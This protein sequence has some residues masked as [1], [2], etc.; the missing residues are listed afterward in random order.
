MTTH[1]KDSR[2]SRIEATYK[3]KDVE[4]VIDIWYYRPLGYA[5]AVGA[6]RLD[7]SPNTISVVGMLIGM[8]G[9]HLF[10]YDDLLLNV[11]GILCWMA[12]QALDGADGQLARMANK[13]STLGRVLDGLSDSFK[14]LSVYVHIA[15]RIFVETGSPLIL[16]VAF[17]AMWFHSAQSAFADYYRNLYLFF[18]YDP[19]KGELDESGDVSAEY[20]KLSWTQNFWEKLLWF[21]YVPYTKMQEALSG[22]VDELRQATLRKFG[23]EIPQSIKDEY[24]RRNKPNIMWYNALTTNTRM[25]VLYFSLFVGNLWIY[26]IADLTYFNLVLLVMKIRQK[27]INQEMM[28]MVTGHAPG[29]AVLAPVEQSA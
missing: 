6:Y 11:L 24:R 22:S 20:R 2:R 19:S 28:A 18:V 13:K 1:Q 29:E 4:E 7:I 23:T 5:I 15:A 9:G 8:L 14:F 27:R 10:F 26:I 16:V 17:A 3:A 12:G 25:L 21:F